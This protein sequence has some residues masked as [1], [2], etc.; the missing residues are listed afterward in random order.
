VILATPLG[1]FSKIV[2]DMAT[3]VCWRIGDSYA[4]VR[5]A[6]MREGVNDASALAE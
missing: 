2:S 4:H 5:V 6:R 1:S 3:S